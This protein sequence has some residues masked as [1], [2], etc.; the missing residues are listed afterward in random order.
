MIGSTWVIPLRLTAGATA[1]VWRA[2]PGR[3]IC[4]SVPYSGFCEQA[5]RLSKIVAVRIGVMLRIIW[6]IREQ[7]WAMP[8]LL[9]RFVYG[10][11]GASGG[12]YFDGPDVFLAASVADE[13]DSVAD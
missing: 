4:G 2:V 3:K 9:L 10:R 1:Q 12:V 7:G 11:R 8:A 13:I 5:D 6:F